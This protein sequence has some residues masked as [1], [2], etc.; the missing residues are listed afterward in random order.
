MRRRGLTVIAALLFVLLLAAPGCGDEEPA[1]TSTGLDKQSAARNEVTVTATPVSTGDAGQ[2]W[3]FTVVF[4]THSVD[5]TQDPAQSAVL[6]ADGREYRPLAWEGPGPG[7][8]HREGRLRFPAISPPPENIELRL[9]GINGADFSFEWSLK[10]PD[11]GLA[12]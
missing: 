4:D 2:E 10:L 11:L 9:E 3:V 7:G 8:H 6:V 5:L 1:P 12:P